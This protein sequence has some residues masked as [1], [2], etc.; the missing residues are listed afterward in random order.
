[1]ILK[2]RIIVYRDGVGDGNIK[3]VLEN[4]VAKIKESLQKIYD[5]RRMHFRFAFVLINKKINTRIFERHD[6]SREKFVNPLPG[7]VVDDVITLPER[8]DFYLISQNAGR[9]TVAPVLY[10]VIDDNLG[11]SSDEMQKFT[12]K[13]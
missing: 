6:N 2:A 13:L 1:M 7:T 10:N 12:Y 5:E 11:L 9:G 3:S 8:T 4:E